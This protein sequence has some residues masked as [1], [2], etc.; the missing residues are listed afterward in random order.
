MLGLRHKFNSLS[1]AFYTYCLFTSLSFS[2]IN[3]FLVH[4]ELYAKFHVFN[5]KLILQLETDYYIYRNG[6]VKEFFEDENVTADS[7]CPINELVGELYLMMT[8]Y[9]LGSVSIIKNKEFKLQLF[10]KKMRYY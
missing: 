7:F 4:D 8:K 6:G 3:P 9:S 2:K 5:R 1:L 10:Y